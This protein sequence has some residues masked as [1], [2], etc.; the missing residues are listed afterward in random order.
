MVYGGLCHRA[1]N[2]HGGGYHRPV[3]YKMTTA[4]TAIMLEAFA[5]GAAFAVSVW[6][7]HRDER[8]CDKRR[9]PVANT[10]LF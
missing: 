1:G 4:L 8:E 6:K 7:E 9:T 3:L 10:A 5:K 2:H